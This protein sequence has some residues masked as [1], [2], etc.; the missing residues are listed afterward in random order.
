M[1]PAPSRLSNVTPL[2]A[3][4]ALVIDA[5]TT[6]LDPAK[7]RL[8]SICGWHMSGGQ[9]DPEPLFDVLVD[10]GVPIPPATTKVHGIDDNAVRGKPPFRTIWPELARRI[11]GHLVIGHTIGYDLAVLKRE[12]ERA[13]LTFLKPRTLDT[14]FLGE[15]AAPRLAGFSLDK[16]AAWLAVPVEDRHSARGDVKVTA[17]VFA[18]LLPKLREKNI[19]TL[20]E[21]EAACLTLIDARDGQARAG[22][23]DPT[24]APRQDMERTLGRIDSYPYRHRIGSVMSTPPLCIT[25]SASIRDALQRMASKRVSSLF[26]TTDPDA[27]A[28]PADAYGIVTERDL[29]RVL[30]EAEHAAF[31]R[32]VGSIASRPLAT[33]PADALIYRAIGRMSRM[34]IRHLG[35]VEEVGTLVGALSQRDLLRLRAEGAVSLGDEIDEATSVPALGKAWAKLPQVARA[36]A[37]EQVSGRDVASVVSRELGAATRRACVLAETAMQAAGHG[38]PPCPYAFAVLGSAGRGES[39]LALDQDNALVFGEGEPDGVND[40]WFAAFAGHVT[41]ALDTIGVPL[42]KGEVMATNPIWRGSSAT[43]RNR[44]ANWIATATPQ[45]LMSVDIFFDLRPVHG[46]PKLAVD[47]WRHAFDL[48]KD[49]LP[50][51]KLLADSAGTPEAGLTFLGGFKTEA[52]RIDLKKAGL[53]GLVSTAR[54]LAIR[55]HVVERSTPARLAGIGARGLGGQDDLKALDAAQAIF[56]DLILA[57]QLD[58]AESGVAPS[59]KV[60]TRRLTSA[61]QQRL[62]TALGAV[63]HMDTLLRDLLFGR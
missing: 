37:A 32:P 44:I 14:R 17:A 13:G 51:V 12:C 19:R 34:R 35:V 5:E 7:A 11:D 3:L 9:L 8:I 1:T 49:Q 61:D 48:A 36:L 20:A 50:F 15:V 39:L 2:V 45:D 52:G 47:L 23:V 26:V 6:D 22:W 10:P 53:F 31:M 58:D 43:W 4:D 33:V 29:L 41:T 16:L 54:V 60:A 59:N 30:A 25:A 46:D 38:P 18:G 42:C 63:R 27:G 24:E 21:A 57:Q 56:L 40:R 28:Q 55:H 62:K